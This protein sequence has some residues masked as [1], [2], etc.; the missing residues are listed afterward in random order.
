MILLQSSLFILYSLQE[1]AIVTYH[2]PGI[3]LSD[4]FDP[5]KDLVWRVLLL[6]YPHLI[7]EETKAQ[8]G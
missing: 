2:V 4:L 1:V 6:Y 5:H 3:V 7:D 8:R